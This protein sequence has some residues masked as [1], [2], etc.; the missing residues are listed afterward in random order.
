[1]S[2]E[3]LVS[4]EY[5]NGRTHYAT[6]LGDAPLKPGQEFEL[7]GRR[8][9]AIAVAGKRQRAVHPERMLCRVVPSGLA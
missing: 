3:S 7:Y 4:L 9:R 2:A 5:P 6:L 1:M 8:W